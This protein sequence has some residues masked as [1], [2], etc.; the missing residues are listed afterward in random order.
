MQN[1]GLL[2]SRKREHLVSHPIPA[3][4]SQRFIALRMYEILDT[5]PEIAYDEI[6]ELA[7]Q[8]C[9]CPVAFISFIDDDRRWLKAKYGLPPRMSQAPR[10][11]AVCSTTIFVLRRSVQRDLKSA[12]CASCLPAVSS[13]R[14]AQRAASGFD[15]DPRSPW[16]ART[17][18]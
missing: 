12:R 16:I 14:E 5:A 11:T 7:A 4:E 18:N 6:A 10:E 13:W 8:I 15:G 2:P 17:N 9:R 3:N 1:L